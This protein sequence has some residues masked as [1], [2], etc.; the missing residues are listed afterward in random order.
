MAQTIT[1]LRQV[2]HLFITNRLTSSTSSTSSGL[3]LSFSTFLSSLALPSVARLSFLVYHPHASPAS[4]QEGRLGT[5]QRDQRPLIRFRCIC[6]S[7]HKWNARNFK[8]SGGV[9]ANLL[10]FFFG[11]SDW[12]GERSVLPCLSFREEGTI[13]IILAGITPN[14][15]QNHSTQVNTQRSSSEPSCFKYR[16]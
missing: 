13:K 9:G 2:G 15:P 5:S 11:R 4:C 8:A 12:L 10:P 16:F 1:T 6:D 14:R 3:S 7:D